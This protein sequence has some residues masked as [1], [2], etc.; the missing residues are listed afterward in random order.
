LV[1]EAT[2][3]LDNITKKDYQT[4]KAYSTPPSGVDMVF[5]SVVWLLAGFFPEAIEIDKNKKPKNYDWKAC[6]KLMKNPDQFVNILR[7]FKD[8]V[9]QNLVPPGNVDFIKKNYL[10]HP[11]FKPEIMAA[12]S[13]AAKGVCEW[14]L[15]IVKYYDVIQ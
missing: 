7:G 11:D 5:A 2:A 3:A 10:S 4:A 9:D 14:V 1:K 13:G 15:N 6:L 12:K 8:T